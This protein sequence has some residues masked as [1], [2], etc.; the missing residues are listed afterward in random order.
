MKGERK[1]RRVGS[2]FFILIFLID[3]HSDDSDSGLRIWRGGFGWYVPV[4]IINTIT[5]C[6]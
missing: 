6:I 5:T 1:E 2:L 4:K 3:L